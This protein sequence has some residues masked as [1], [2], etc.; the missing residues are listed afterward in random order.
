[1]TKRRR[2]FGLFCVVTLCLFAGVAQAQDVAPQ[3]GINMA[4]MKFVMIPPL[5]TCT[6]G[7]VVSGNPA[8][9]PSVILAKATNGCVIPWHWH[10]PNENV[11]IVSGLARFQMK[12]GKPV[13]LNAGGFALMPSHHQH[14]FRCLR[15]CVLYIYSD[16]AFDIHYVDQ[17]GNE[18][19]PADAMKAVREKWQ[20]K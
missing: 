4:A 14:E 6:K 16:A 3:P 13:T 8:Q 1:M 9:G 5:P 20:Q 7:S 19:Q 2:W 18:I 12:D 15:T 11:M 10:T 17:Q